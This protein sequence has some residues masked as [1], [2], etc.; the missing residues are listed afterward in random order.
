MGRHVGGEGS[1]LRKRGAALLASVALLQPALSHPCLRLP[2]PTC[3]RRSR[4]RPLQHGPARRPLAPALQLWL[5]QRQPGGPPPGALVWRG[6]LHPGAGVPRHL[7]RWVQPLQP[8]RGGWD[9]TGA[10]SLNPASDRRCGR[11]FLHVAR[12]LPGG[13]LPPG[14]C[15]RRQGGAGQLRRPVSALLPGS[16]A[17]H[18]RGVVFG[19]VLACAGL[20]AAAWVFVHQGHGGPGGVTRWY[21]A[22]PRSC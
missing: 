8:S 2:R 6:A 18:A 9:V 1:G 12:V 16:A 5:L 14:F 11:K 21:T 7:H 19:G 4:G 17:R 20:K 15:F 3:P 22:A 10:T 13:P